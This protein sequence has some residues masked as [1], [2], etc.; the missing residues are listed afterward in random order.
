[1]GV[2]LGGKNLTF[3]DLNPNE[4]HDFSLNKLGDL[5]I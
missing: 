4:L 3:K 2:R 5:L 1:M